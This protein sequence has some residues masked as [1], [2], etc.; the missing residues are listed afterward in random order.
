MMVAEE[1]SISLIKQRYVPASDETTDVIDSEALV[2]P[3][4]SSNTPVVVFSFCH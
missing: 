2:L 1:P 3:D 4:K